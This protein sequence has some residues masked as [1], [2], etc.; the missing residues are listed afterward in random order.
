LVAFASSGS[1]GAGGKAAATARQANRGEH[2]REASTMETR[3]IGDL[4]VSVAGLGCNNFGM[5]VDEARSHAVVHAALD[6][7]IT[8]FD[9]AD[10]YGGAGTSEEYLGR[11]LGSR[12]DDVVIT[13]KFGMLQPPDGL[14]GGSPEWVPRAAEDSLRRLGT[15]HIDLYVLHQPDPDTAIGDT[16]EALDAL[17]MAGKV[18]EIGC[19]NFTSAQID[20][21]A[22]AAAERGVRP[23]VNVQNEYSLLQRRPERNVIPA[24]QRYG[25]TLTPY[26]PLASGLLTGKYRL[27]ALARAHGHTLHELALSW[28]ASNPIVATV[29]AGATIPEQVRANVAATLAWPV[30]DEERAEVDE[31][32]GR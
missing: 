9:T 24:V 2:A 15:D 13:T 31:I 4:E 19:S 3:R 23:F 5:R 14:T 8:C 17:V 25:M 26:F 11:A 12:S 6:A 21:A 27:D 16:L 18:R 7:G 22:A 20:D 30:S 32:L 10:L 28:L 29:I 1:C